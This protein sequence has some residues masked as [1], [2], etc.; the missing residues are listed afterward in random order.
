MDNSKNV[1][2]LELM[3]KIIEGGLEAVV[4]TEV[5]ST[6]ADMVP[7]PKGDN[8]CCRSRVCRG[9]CVVPSSNNSLTFYAEDNTLNDDVM[10]DEEKEHKIHDKE[11]ATTSHQVVGKPLPVDKDITEQYLAGEISFKELMIGMKIEG[12]GSS[13]EF[14]SED[15]DTDQEWTPSARS[16]STRRK[17]KSRDN[18]QTDVDQQ[19]S[20][21]DEEY[22]YKSVK[23]KG[24]CAGVRRKKLDP[25]LKGLMGE[26]H[27]RFAK[28][29]NENGKKM[30]LE[31]IR[32]DPSAPEPFQALANLYEEGEDLEKGLQFALIAAQL[33]PPDPDEWSRLA[34][35]SLEQSDIK[36]ACFC[37]KKAI[38]A[39][40]VNVKF[41]TVRCNL[42]EQIGDKSAALRCYKKML[43]NLKSD[44][45]QDFL[46]GSREA[47]R[48][49]HEKD[50]L[51]QAQS[52]FDE[53]FSRFPD[54]IKDEDVNLFLEM[55]LI[56]ENYEHALE[57]CCK[58]ANI[59]FDCKDTDDNFAN[60]EPKRQLEAFNDVIVPSDVTADIQYKLVII[61]VN[62]NARHLCSDLLSLFLEADPEEFGDFMLE[63][64]EALMKNKHF[65]DAILY[66]EKLV[67]SERYSEAAVWLQFAESLFNAGRLE[68]SEEAYKQVVVLAPHHYNARLQLSKIMRNLGR[69]DDALRALAQD[70][71]EEM[72]SP[73]LLFN[74]C[75]LL[76]EEHKEEE[77][78]EKSKL[79]LSRHFVNIRNKE[80]LHAI[81][82]AKRISSKNKALTEVRN[83]RR[84]ALTETEAAEF[85]QS[86]DDISLKEE[87]KLFCDTCDLLFEH[88][89]YEELQRL[90]F[91]ALGSPVFA[92]DQTVLKECEFLCLLASF[93]NGDSYHAY[94][95][96]R[97]LVLKDIK[98]QAVWNMFNVVIM[99]ADDVRHNR[100]LM[101]LMS[102]NTDNLALGILNGHNCLVAGTYKY[103]LG[104][105]M[106]AFKQDSSN[107]LIALMLA[108]TFC[109]MACQKFSGKKHSLVVQAC[110]FLNTY[111]ELR[112]ECQE[113]YYNLG[114]TMHQ[115]NILPAALHYYKKALDLGPIIYNEPIFDLKAEIAYNISLIYQGSG[116]LEL[117]RYYI[118]KFIVI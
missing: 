95:C 90:A 32:Q 39:D 91:S 116:N 101:R 79:F 45:G 19:E 65:K 107:P 16:S 25:A 54:L 31:I 106:S 64:A 77:F 99:R 49:F 94:N 71:T 5:V 53:A 111:K 50:Q 113:V 44:Q 57:I 85:E 108:L 110:A 102:R 87:F 60:L 21:D 10:S 75:K 59:S 67:N 8:Q 73:H 29:D 13:E 27:L 14:D 78:L 55:L 92:R 42:L 81:S 100:F 23:K 66:F 80:E 109:H 35:M 52:I 115:L 7:V 63:I 4:S 84:E 83:F 38:E 70:E 61:L 58:Y 48:L 22:T 62:L 26:A 1:E 36:Q 43:A 30:C 37:Y 9:V 105:Y 15:Q 2:M 104:E 34:D 112:G 96:V 72:L 47:A 20:G 24:R 98:N 93:Y 40:P 28:G 88:Q 18:D 103:S 74:R 51:S 17:A 68:D 89:R 3:N 118:E 11:S 117:A 86:S 33:A 41:Y 6:N 12:D 76:L 46:N 82:S 114:R 69:P 97:D 56:L